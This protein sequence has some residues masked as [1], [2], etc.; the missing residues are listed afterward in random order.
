MYPKRRVS[1][2]M[3]QRYL[4]NGDRPKHTAGGKELASK[5]LKMARKAK[6]RE[7]RQAK[8]ATMLR[9]EEHMKMMVR[10]IG[11]RASTGTRW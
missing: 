11:E 9:K 7:R 6:K 8:W 3:V 5:E 4:D 10:A 2:K 1:E